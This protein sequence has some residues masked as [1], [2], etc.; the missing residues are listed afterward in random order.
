[1]LENQLNNGFL[2]GWTKLLDQPYSHH[3]K[4]SDVEAAPAGS[5]VFLGAQNPSGRLVIG[6][7][8]K[9][10]EVIRQT[11]GNQVKEHFGLYWFHSYGRSFGFSKNSQVNLNSA[12]TASSEA[13]CRLSWHSDQSI[14]G[15]RA[16]ARNVGLN[17]QW[18]KL[19]YFKE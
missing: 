10:E 13:E 18:R 17:G 12:D 8:G 14:G 9:R 16:G 6:G 2:D 1:M 11:S 3:S 19:I 4:I 5:L 7:V 15:Y